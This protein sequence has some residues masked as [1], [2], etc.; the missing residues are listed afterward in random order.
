VSDE[1][2]VVGKAERRQA[3]TAS[4]IA[5]QQPEPGTAR[6]Q[7]ERLLGREELERLEHRLLDLLLAE[8]GE[9]EPEPAFFDALA[10]H[11]A[12]ERLR[13]RD[14][15]L[16]RPTPEATTTPTGVASFDG[17]ARQSPMQPSPTH[18]QTLIAVLRSGEANV[19]ANF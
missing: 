10:A 19:G 12:E 13:L 9:P 17:G 2:P 15:L 16:G 11:Q 3:L 1:P 7:L 5:G 14:A 18:E 4:I 8:Q 6:E